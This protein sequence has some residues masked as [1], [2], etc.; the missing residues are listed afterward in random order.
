[1]PS[2]DATYED[3]KRYFKKNTLTKIPE[4]L[5]GIWNLSSL[6][7]M[8]ILMTFE[9]AD[10]DE[11]KRQLTVKL[12]EKGNWLYKEE[13]LFTSWLSKTVKYAYQFNFNEDYTKAEININLG[14]CKCRIP[15]S[16]MHWTMEMKDG[17]M[18]RT[19]KIFSTIHEYKATKLAVPTDM[20]DLRMYDNFYY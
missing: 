16:M 13:N 1:M 12:Y 2:I 5:N 18:I 9:N 19:T 3:V 10:F 8:S 4:S 6:G 15:S 7:N 20:Y 11:D 14:K 17:E